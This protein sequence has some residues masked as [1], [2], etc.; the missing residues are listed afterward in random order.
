MITRLSEVW[1]SV[2][3]VA[4]AEGVV[5]IGASDLTDA[6]SG[7]FDDWLDRGHHATMRYLEKSAGI[8]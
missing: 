3:C 2:E 5:R 1:E 8:R 7:L 6:H 4:R